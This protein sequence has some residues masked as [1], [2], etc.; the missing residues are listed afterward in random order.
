MRVQF[1]RDDSFLAWTS[2][3]WICHNIPIALKEVLIK[4]S[5]QHGQSHE[6]LAKG[7][8]KYNSPSHVSWHENGSYYYQTD[9]GHLWNFQSS[10]TQKGWNTLWHNHQENS[11]TVRELKSLAV[12]TISFAGCISL[13]S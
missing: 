4:E 13:G 10:I 9:E 7:L 1:G 6:G 12:S 11:F 8:F 3:L 5:T 2:C